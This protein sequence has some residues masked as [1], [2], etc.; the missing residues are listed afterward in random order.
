M[1]IYTAPPEIDSEMNM[2]D[3][4]VNY[5]AGGTC[6]WGVFYAGEIKTLLFRAIVNFDVSALSGRTIN[7]A[8]LV[9]YIFSVQGGGWAATIY[10]CTRPSTWTEGGVTWNKYDGANTWTSEGGDLDETTP[11]PKTLTETSSTGRHEISG[12]GSFVTDALSLRSGLVSLIMRA[13]DEDPGTT[14]YV[15]WHSKESTGGG[16]WRLVV[17]HSGDP[18][19]L[20]RHPGRGFLRGFQRGFERGGT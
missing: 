19:G 1:S 4:D 2:E 16:R 6:D 20:H 11:T 3:P 13:D 7:S 18:I 10:R 5:G 8:K 9:R 12:M 17:D 14:K 15:N